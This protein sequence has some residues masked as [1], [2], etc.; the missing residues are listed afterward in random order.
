[1]DTVCLLAGRQGDRHSVFA[2]GLGHRAG[3]PGAVVADAT[4]TGIPRHLLFHRC[5]PVPPVHHHA[6]HDHGDLS[7]H[8]IVPRRLRQLPDPAD[9]RRPGHG[10][11]IC[12][13][14]ELLGLPA[15]G[16]GAGLDILRPRRPHRRRL[17][18]IPAASNPLRNARAGLGHHSHDVVP[19]PVHHR[20]HDGRL[21]L[22]GH[23][24]AG[25][26]PRHD[27]DAPAPDGVGAFSRRP[28]WRCWHSLH[29]SSP[30]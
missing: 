1:M 19:D 6:R 3:G 8:R 15:R 5:Q 21:E 11:P 4:A 24:A 2:D 20:L 30:R 14:A 18:A 25:A 26:H 10:L 13:H 12:E 28:S 7:A 17:D 9:G 16:P 29:S 22:C 27:V 23:G